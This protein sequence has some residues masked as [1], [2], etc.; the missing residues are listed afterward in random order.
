LLKKLTLIS[1]LSISL[2]TACTGRQEATHRQLLQGLPPAMIDHLIS[3]DDSTFFQYGREVGIRILLD[4]CNKVGNRMHDRII[5]DSP[6]E[7]SILRGYFEKIGRL[8]D[9]EYNY[10][11]YLDELDL[12][13][14]LSPA[15]QRSLLKLENEFYSFRTRIEL[16]VLE[17]IERY[18]DFLKPFDKYQDLLFMALCE[19]EISYAYKTLGNEREQI[20]YL[21]ASQRHFDQSGLHVM[22]CPV[23]CELGSYHRD[24]GHTDS[25]I[26]YY[27]KA[28]KLAHHCRLPRETAQVNSYYANYYESIGHS[29]LAFHLLRK[30]TQ[31]CRKYKGEY[32]ELE[33]IIETMNYQA[34]FGCWRAVSQMLDRARILQ[35]RYRNTTKKYLKLY[36]LQIDLIDARMQMTRGNMDKAEAIFHRSREAIEHLRMPYTSEPETAKLLAFQARGLLENGRPDKA[37]HIINQ[38]YE[39]SRQA[40]L[41]EFSARFALLKAKATFLINDT[42]TSLNSLQQFESI[43]RKC[44][45]S[46]Q[47]QW[48]ER[49]AL[50]G[51]LKLKSR[52]RQA[53]F[54]ALEKGLERLYEYVTTRDGSAQSYLW[55]SKCRKLRLLMHDITVD[56]PMLGY[57]A[58][59]FWR[60]FYALLGHQ[61]RMI[62]NTASSPPQTGNDETI[63]ERHGKYAGISSILRNRAKSTLTRLEK[64]GAVHSIYLIHDRHIQRWTASSSG[65]RSETLEISTAEAQKLTTE[66]SKMIL[67]DY[68]NPGAVQTNKL[69]KKL[70]KLAHSLLPYQIM[71]T[72]STPSTP[73]YAPFFITADGFLNQLPFETLDVGNKDE[74]VPLLMVCDVAYLRHINK[75][76]GNQVIP[77]SG[78]LESG[79]NTP[80]NY[81]PGKPVSGQ[82]WD[83]LTK[84]DGHI[85]TS[86]RNP[87]TPELGDQVTESNEQTNASAGKTD[88]PTGVIL[89]NPEP[90]NK[91]LN[92]YPL[93]SELKEAMKEGEKV[94]SSN[95]EAR[96]LKGV[97]ASKANL[98]AL[99]EKVS[100]IYIASHMLRDPQ[101]PYLT[102]I[103]LA[104][105]AKV[106][107]P[108]A[109]VVDIT[110]IRAADLSKCKIVVLSG[111]SSGAP[112]L[113]GLISGPSLGDAFLDAGADAVVFT[114]WDIL[115]REAGQLMAS[116]FGEWEKWDSSPVH[117]L[118]HIRRMDIRSSRQPN[119][120]LRWASYSIKIGKL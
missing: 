19:Y 61:K 103:P 18:L 10:T 12:L 73:H 38:G 76:P 9:S 4:A 52:D 90:S 36:A 16:P 35:N 66:A 93:Q 5:S 56:D 65:V 24:K 85:N 104:S 48:I 50:I 94:A 60:D 30:A 120:P 58:E 92:R 42:Q 55:M 111:C 108:D 11:N 79:D 100:Y 107:G 45:G 15:D 97:S 114:F 20:E 54:S 51:K 87:F 84:D 95:P 26:Y 64:L 6:E 118:C 70:R 99:W 53:A 47:H 23:L 106:S 67:R 105:P 62:D 21:R 75:S 91:F 96:F 115:D 13:D 68:S 89:V 80:S 31:I 57:G 3:S 34:D 112:Y 22:T 102:I 116:Y 83:S 69:Q 8:L 28:S 98:L 29:S 46:L 86:A 7:A 14:K 41:P 1:F 39:I 82:L 101:F 88:E 37:I 119:H 109:E 27:E 32:S 59:L 17:K 71:E 110:D 43:A 81:S 78:D 25:M 33:F 77:E 117:K 40:K 63:S 49:D 44:E 74:Y 2:L 72:P 113:E